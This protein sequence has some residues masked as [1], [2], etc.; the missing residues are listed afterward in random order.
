MKELLLTLL[1]YNYEAN[2]VVLQ[3]ILRLPQPDEAVALLSH[4]IYAQDKWHNRFTRQQPDARL[5]WQGTSYA[6][7]ML[8]AEWKRSSDHWIK[9]VEG[10]DEAGLQDDL[11]F[12]RAADGA[13][14]AVSLRDLI[15]QLNLHAVHHR[16]QIN[17]LISAQ[18]IPVPPTDYIFNVL[19]EISN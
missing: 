2:L 3:S 16:A 8:A 10:L 15:I 4:M 11:R 14:M 18:G 1:R 9:L 6:P 12:I 19:R 17:K 13:E 7:D 5:G